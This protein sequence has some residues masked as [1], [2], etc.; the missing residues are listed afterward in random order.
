MEGLN[1]PVKGVKKMT[2]NVT[3]EV[4]Q[5]VDKWGVSIPAGITEHCEMCGRAIK[6]GKVQRIGFSQEKGSWTLNDAEATQGFF[7][8]GPDCYKKAVKQLENG[9]QPDMH[10]WDD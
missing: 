3:E 9:I 1:I 6:P 10:R 8:F 5:N 2:Q 7:A 4:V